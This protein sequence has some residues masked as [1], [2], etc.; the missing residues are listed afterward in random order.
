MKVFIF[1]FSVLVDTV[2]VAFPMGI[3]H[4]KKSLD[5]VILVIRSSSA[6]LHINADSWTNRELW[7]N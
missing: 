6:R 5:E 3:T 7:Y 2:G 4:F 1:I